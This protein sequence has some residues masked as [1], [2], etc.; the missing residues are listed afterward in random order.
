MKEDMSRMTPLLCGMPSQSS[1]TF[2]L[3]WVG[4]ADVQLL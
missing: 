2:A 4:Q 3:I 1:L